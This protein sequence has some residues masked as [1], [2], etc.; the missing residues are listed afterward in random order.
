MNLSSLITSRGAATASL[1]LGCSFG[2]VAQQDPAPAKPTIDPPAARPAAKGDYTATSRLIGA[3][4]YLQASAEQVAEAARDGDAADRPKAKVTE[5]LINTT[6]G[7]LCHA[8]VSIGGFLGIGDKVVLVPASELK[9]NNSMERYDLAWTKE[10]LKAHPTF[11]L[12]D[13]HKKGLDL[14]CGMKGDGVRSEPGLA[15]AST[16]RDPATKT[17]DPV[18]KGDPAAKSDPAVRTT[19]P[20]AKMFAHATN[21]VCKASELA[22]LPIYA[23]A[24]E[25]GK[26]KD[27]IVD[28][29]Q[30]RVVLA[31]V[32]HG[33]TLGV[34]G[35]D[36]LVPFRHFALCQKD[37]DE[38]I[39][40][41][42][43]W[44]AKLQ[45][46]VKFEKPKNGVVDPAA[47]KSALDGAPMKSGN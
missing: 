13:A 43:Q 3:P 15:D 4:V 27:L 39:L 34:G 38:P 36:Y 24:A 31:V 45:G 37:A 25:W 18:V 46:S 26:A 6:D 8:V 17:G 7:K 30:N 40:C 14:A 29:E 11:D 12:A 21:K 32:N 35:D 41:G 47:A 28:R 42:E 20:A 2:L 33:A 23:G 44:P 1:L 19:E 9:W 10:Q 22:S 5:W 16:K